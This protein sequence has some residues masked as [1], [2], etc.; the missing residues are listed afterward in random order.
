M[1]RSPQQILLWIISRRTI[2]AVSSCCESLPFIPRWDE[3]LFDLS[4]S[5]SSHPICLCL[6]LDTF[7][8]NVANH[9]F[10]STK[11]LKYETIHVSDFHLMMTAS[12][13]SCYSMISRS[14][15]VCDFEAVIIASTS[16]CVSGRE[17]SAESI[18]GIFDDHFGCLCCFCS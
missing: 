7:F 9:D 8:L 17:S 5:E 3:P 2:R 13:H 10:S 4:G 14:T 1:I 15:Q 11:H 18:T 6:A 16:Y 12:A